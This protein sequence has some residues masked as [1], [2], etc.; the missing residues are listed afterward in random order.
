MCQSAY[1]GHLY[2]LLALI[3]PALSQRRPIW[4]RPL[5]CQEQIS[6]YRHLGPLLTPK[7][8]NMSNNATMRRLKTALNDFFKK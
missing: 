1:L 6:T 8:Q 2:T 3:T 7:C 5:F 4:R